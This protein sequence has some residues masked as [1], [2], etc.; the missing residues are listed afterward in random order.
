MNMTGKNNEIAKNK[1]KRTK[2]WVLRTGIGQPI[3]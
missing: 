2:S 3:P 1:I